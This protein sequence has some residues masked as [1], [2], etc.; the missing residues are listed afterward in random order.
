V[1]SFQ[2]ALEEYAA[3]KTDFHGTLLEELKKQTYAQQDSPQMLCDQLEGRLL[4]MLV[5]LVQA[6]RVLEIGTFTGY[7]ALSMAE[8]LPENGELISLEKNPKAIEFARK[9]FARSPHG[10]KI[11]IIEG[12]AL[13]SL[14][15]VEGPFDL[16]FIDAD[17]EHYPDYYR[18]ALPKVRSGGLIAADNVLWSGRVLDPKS[19][20]DLAICRFNDEV[21]KDPSVEKVLL[22]VRDGVFLIRK[23]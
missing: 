5:Q 17:K 4:K 12:A 21:C 20:S 2:P 7:S 8:G 13:D 16:V 18:A 22:T 9:F 10:K 11:K 19:E 23:R 14:S 15:R 3:S 1:L 6:T